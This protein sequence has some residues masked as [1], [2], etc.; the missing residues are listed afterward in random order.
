MGAEAKDAIL[1][2]GILSL[3]FG[4]V[5]GLLASLFLGG[6]LGLWL[7]GRLFDL[8]RA[9]AL[10]AVGT[11]ILTQFVSFAVAAVLSPIP[12][13]GSII[14][15][16][17]G[18]AASVKIVERLFGSSL[19]QACI[20]VVFRMV[21]AWMTGMVVVFGFLGGVGTLAVVFGTR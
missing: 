11:S 1:A 6:A 7:G 2:G 3:G 17:L 10:R 12:L 18:L 8:P 19:G 14:G 20:C 5:A 9:T 13:L 21:T 4:L 15:Y 16:L